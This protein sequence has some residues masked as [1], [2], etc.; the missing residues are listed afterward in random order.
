MAE[1]ALSAAR[2]IMGEAPVRDGEVL[3]DEADRCIEQERVD[4]AYKYL[5]QATAAFRRDGDRL[6]QATS[7][8]YLAELDWRAERQTEL[9]AKVAQIRG[10]CHPEGATSEHG[11][12]L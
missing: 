6:G 3:L 12:I 8:L 7:L 2:P 10:L 11:K 9:E 1:R 5:T 4:D